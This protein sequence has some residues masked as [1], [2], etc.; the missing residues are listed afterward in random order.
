MCRLYHTIN[1]AT[2][3]EMWMETTTASCAAFTGN[4]RDFH[5]NTYVI[6]DLLIGRHAV[7][8]KAAVC[9]KETSNGSE[10]LRVQKKQDLE[11]ELF[12]IMYCE[13]T[14]FILLRFK[15]PNLLS[16]PLNIYNYFACAPFSS[17]LV[18]YFCY[19]SYLWRVPW[20]H[21]LKCVPDFIDTCQC[22]NLGC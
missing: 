10:M 3:T 7:R 22:R 2:L 14:S 9:G 5:A 15:N 17:T 21:K 4:P 13:R 1:Q 19:T 16:S 11:N 20:L 18:T 6:V 12:Q 8:I